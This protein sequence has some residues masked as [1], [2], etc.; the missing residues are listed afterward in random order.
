MRLSRLDCWARVNGGRGG[1]GS[2]FPSCCAQ[3]H[4]QSSMLGKKATCKHRKLCLGPSSDSCSLRD[5]VNES[6]LC[7]GYPLT[8]SVRDGAG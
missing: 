3:L 8:S 7:P 1:K 2:G 6:F 4:V 5:L